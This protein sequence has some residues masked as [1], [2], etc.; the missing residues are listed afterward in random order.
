MPV[1]CCSWQLRNLKE[2]KQIHT[3][4]RKQ[5]SE[6]YTPDDTTMWTLTPDLIEMLLRKLDYYNKEAHTETAEASAS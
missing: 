5:F 3:Q 1:F 6:Y 4:L 2:A